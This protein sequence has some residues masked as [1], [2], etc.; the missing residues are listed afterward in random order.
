MMLHNTTNQIV[1]T[2]GRFNIKESVTST[3]YKLHINHK[4]HMISDQIDLNINWFHTL[5][6]TTFI[7][8]IFIFI[9]VLS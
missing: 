7:D 8:N 6:L 5:V 4:V 2:D 3:I 9:D 1:G